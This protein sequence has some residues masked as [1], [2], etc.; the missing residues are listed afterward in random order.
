MFMYSKN[1]V[2]DNPK[3]MLWPLNDLKETLEITC[4]DSVIHQ[5]LP[6]ETFS[7]TS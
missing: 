3:K 7:T 6:P 2:I 1:S 4:F 5:V